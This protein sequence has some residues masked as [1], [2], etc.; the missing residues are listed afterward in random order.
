MPAFDLIDAYCQHLMELGR[1]ERTIADRHHILSRMD[2]DLPQ[3]LD[4]AT[5]D[6]VRRWIHRP[7]WKAQTRATYLGA[8]HS[9]FA[10][11]T[12]PTRL[13]L[14]YDPSASCPRPKIAPAIPKPVANEQLAYILAHAA[15]PYRFWS[16]VAAY[17]GAR[18]IEISRM[19]RADITEQDT[20][21]HGK[22]DRAGVTPTHPD[23]WAAALELPPGP[24]ARTVGGRR[25][26]ARY[27][28]VR[29]LTHFQEHL[30][31]PGVSMHRLR[32]WYG[33]RIQEQTG[34]IRVTQEALRHSS[35]TSTAGYTLVANRRLRAAVA[36]LPRLSAAATQ[37]AE[38]DAV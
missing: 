35:V 25:A 20:Y 1:S 31:M 7:D 10:F 2:S 23:V 3:G 32:H 11:C 36:A 22:G 15:E 19:D 28:S 26:S 37:S 38:N 24:I 21:L 34:D 17:Q 12:D 4:A 29:A 16:L 27:V 18:C 33:T 13:Y 5:D 8:A 30:G 6:E 9:F 14:D